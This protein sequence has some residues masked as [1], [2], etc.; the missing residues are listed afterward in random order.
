M[1]K[2][3]IFDYGGVLVEDN[4]EEI[5][6]AIAK[7]INKDF[8]EIRYKIKK[9]LRSFQKS[10]LSQSDYFK[11]ISKSLDVDS[12]KLKKIWIM[13]S[14][15]TRGNTQVENLIKKLKRKGYKIALLSNTIPYGRYLKN[16]LR[17]FSVKVFSKNNMRKPEL[18]I[19]KLV[20]EKLCVQPKE[21]LFIDNRTVNL[22]PARRI[23]MKTILFESPQQLESDVAKILKL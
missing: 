22:V 6:E 19:Y 5:S 11:L 7:K 16:H 23:G 14:N 2:A 15:K 17:L 8:I 10:K 9:F 3:V 20:I 18:A 1:I 4:I 21:C 12:K 13:E